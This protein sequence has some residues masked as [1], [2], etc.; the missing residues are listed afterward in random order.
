M[1]IADRKMETVLDT[2]ET[3]TSN[4]GE[5]IFIQTNITRSDQV[6]ALIQKTMA[7]YGQLDIAVNNA[8]IAG[9]SYNGG[10]EYKE[11]QLLMS[12]GMPWL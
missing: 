11:M 4:N 3:I 1:V 12:L 2:L 10:A 9:N 5:A 7:Q 6:Q 8:G